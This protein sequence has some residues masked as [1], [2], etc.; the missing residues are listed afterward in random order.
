V[1]L[2][3]RRSLRETGLSYAAHN[4]LTHVLYGRRREALELARKSLRP[5][6]DGSGPSD[7]VPRMRL[8]TTLG[9]AGAPETAR[10]TASLQAQRPEATLVSGVIVPAARAAIALEG[11]RP[12]LAL[13]ALGPATAYEA[14]NVA[15][16]IPR[17]LRA[18]AW[19]RTG[20]PARALEEYERILAQRGADPFSPVVALAPLGVA[21]A[22]AALGEREA[23]AA[24][25]RAFIEG[26]S[27]ADPD[28]PVLLEARQEAQKLGVH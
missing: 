10:L 5:R 17:H 15:V 1:E 18:E 21:R 26:W 20:Q 11:G 13:Q 4:A 6:P 25:Y 8:L 16:L 23:A 9:L 19:M 22:R 14:G 27:D 3:E 24:A 28:V 2:A 7:A 12:E